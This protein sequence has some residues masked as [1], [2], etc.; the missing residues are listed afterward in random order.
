MPVRC[1]NEKGEIRFIP[2]KLAGMP[3]YMRR[4]NLTQDNVETQEP[5]KPLKEAN[6]I[7]EPINENQ[8]SSEG[9]V[10]MTPQDEI[11]KEEYWAMLDTKGVEYKKT[12]GVAKLKEINDAN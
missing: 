2:D 10:D 4:H 9:I 5:L 8:V 1:L 6:L 7:V 11:T 12:Y 3:D